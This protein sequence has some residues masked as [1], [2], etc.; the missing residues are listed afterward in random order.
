MPN[1]QWIARAIVAFVLVTAAAP[2]A[3]AGIWAWGCASAGK[4]GEQ[5][6]FNRYEL[7]MLD[8]PS[9]LSLKLVVDGVRGLANHPSRA[10]FDA[11]D[12]NSGFEPKLAF[13]AAEGKPRLELAERSSKRISYRK[14]RAGPRDE[15]TTRWRKVYRISGDGDKARNVAMNCMEYILTSKGVRS[16]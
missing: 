15:I 2:Q 13:E 10:R 6:I 5:I 1:R 11:T 9:A 12:A 4:D 8:K 16:E 3:H 7:L 14:G